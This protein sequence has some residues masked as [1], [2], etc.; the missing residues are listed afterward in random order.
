M[1]DVIQ[2]MVI[3]NGRQKRRNG[4]NTLRGKDICR[5]DCDGRGRKV[6]A[7]SCGAIAVTNI[8]CLGA[9]LGGIIYRGRSITMSRIERRGERL[10]GPIP[11]REGKCR[12]TAQKG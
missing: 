9:D 8:D 6:D 1:S 3:R 12:C 4:S 5:R 2:I 7:S 10:T 11:G